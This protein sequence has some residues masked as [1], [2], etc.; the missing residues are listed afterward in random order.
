MPSSGPRWLWWEVGGS[1]C[2]VRRPIIEHFCLGDSKQVLFKAVGL[3]LA[4]QTC[5]TSHWLTITL[6]WYLSDFHV[7]NNWFVIQELQHRYFDSTD[8]QFGT[9]ISSVGSSD[10]LS[11]VVSSLN[12]R[13]HQTSEESD[14]CLL[15]SIAAQDTVHCSQNTCFVPSFWKVFSFNPH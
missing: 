15:W 11:H 1:I 12:E 8:R 9:S 14:D 13:P 6:V 5:A 4:A 7:F 3:W 10:C 2:G